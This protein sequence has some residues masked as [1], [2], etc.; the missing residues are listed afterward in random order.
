MLKVYGMLTGLSTYFK[1]ILASGGDS[2]MKTLTSPGWDLEIV[3]EAHRLGVGART[4]WSAASLGRG[5][6]KATPYLLLLLATPH[7]GK[8]DAFHRLI[9]LVHTQAFSDLSSVTKVWVQP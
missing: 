9:S 4:G 3:D 5:V 8:S 7:Q 6:V 1:C 2:P